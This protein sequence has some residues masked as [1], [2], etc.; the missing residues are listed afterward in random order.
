MTCPRCGTENRD[1]SVFC[2]ECGSTLS[3]PQDLGFAPVTMTNANLCPSCGATLA[4][5]AAFCGNCGATLASA[6]APPPAP[7]ATVIERPALV[8]PMP[9][10]PVE[11]PVAAPPM[12]PPPSPGITP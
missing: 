2:K 6:A 9:S 3:A 1:G 5:N 8:D 10:P 7:G 4:P 12:Y 11:P